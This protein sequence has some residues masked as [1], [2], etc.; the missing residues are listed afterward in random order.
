MNNY[1]KRPGIT[2]VWTKGYEEIE[3]EAVCTLETW[4]G[5]PKGA[6]FEVALKEEP[7]KGKAENRESAKS[8][9]VYGRGPRHGVAQG[10]ENR[11]WEA[12]MEVSM[13]T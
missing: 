5:F 7:E 4:G 3:A 1:H 8:Q 11:R 12:R 13:G 9:Q 6:T 10:S 2:K